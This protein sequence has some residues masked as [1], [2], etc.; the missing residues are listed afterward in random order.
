[1]DEWHVDVIR[2]L[3]LFGRSACQSVFLMSSV[4]LTVDPIAGYFRGVCDVIILDLAFK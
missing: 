3:F 4:C 2:M 1:M